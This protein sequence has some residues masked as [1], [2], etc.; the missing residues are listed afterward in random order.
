MALHAKLLLTV[1]HASSI[2]FTCF[3]S[4]V[5]IVNICEKIG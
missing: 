1:G 2:S 5:C 4:L 3:Q